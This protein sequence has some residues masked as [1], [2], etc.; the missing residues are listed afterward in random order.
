MAAFSL[1]AVLPAALLWATQVGATTFPAT[2]EVDL[3]FPRNETYAPSALFPIVFAFQNAA[4]VPSLDPGFDLTLWDSTGNNTIPGQPVLNLW[5]TNFSGNDPTYVYTYVTAL[6]TTE[7]GASA[8]HRLT[9]GFSAGNCSDKYGAL[10]FGGGFVG[11][12]VEFTIQS[13]AQQPD[14]V[15]ATANSASCANITHF[16]FNLTGTLD[17][18]VPAEHDGRNTCAVFSDVQ[19]QVA[20][21]PCAVQV[22]SATA[23]SIS[24]ALTAT[25]CAAANPVV[26]CKS[27]NAAAKGWKTGNTAYT[28]VLGGLV[29]A[30]VAMQ[31]L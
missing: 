24:A 1:S 4:L 2:V 5:A 19:P 3:I 28:A 16:A 25:A 15:A 13:G 8:S 10:T 27:T 17:V 29:V 11:S 23:S 12:G 20:G 6:N 31:C 22:S 7:G 18:A 26:S 14:L 30:F 9:W 21:N